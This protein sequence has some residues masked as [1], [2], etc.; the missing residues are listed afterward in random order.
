MWRRN[1][2]DG[3]GYKQYYTCFQRAVWWG[4]ATLNLATSWRPPR[5]MRCTVRTPNGNRWPRALQ[6]DQQPASIGRGYASWSL[7]CD[8]PAYRSNN[9]YDP[10]AIRPTSRRD[11]FRNSCTSLCRQVWSPLVQ[12]LIVRWS[13]QEEFLSSHLSNQG[14]ASWGTAC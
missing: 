14:D 7:P 2:R 13:G 6:C 12:R 8:R 4:S 3:D 5:S 11:S 10:R 1:G 9:K